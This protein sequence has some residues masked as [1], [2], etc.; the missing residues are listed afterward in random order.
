MLRRECKL[1]VYL[2]LNFLVNVGIFVFSLPALDAL[3]LCS[4]SNVPFLSHYTVSPDYDRNCEKEPIGKELFRI[5]CE[6]N[7]KF[8]EAIDFL[9]SVVST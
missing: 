4:F 5:F 9:D 8:K 1:S 2:N 6:T 7:P 3:W